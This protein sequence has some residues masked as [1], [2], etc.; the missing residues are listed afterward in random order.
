MMQKYVGVFIT[1]VITIY[2]KYS[3]PSSIR[4]RAKRRVQISH[5][6]DTKDGNYCTNTNRNSTYILN[7]N[8]NVFVSSLVNPNKNF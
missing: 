2:R 7:T 6:H 1:I 4:T 5:Q 3:V 8:T